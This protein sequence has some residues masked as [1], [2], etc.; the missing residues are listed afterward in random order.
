MKH[1]L[2]FILLTSFTYGYVGK[3]SS[4]KGEVTLTRDS[5][6]LTATTGLELHKKDTITTGADGKAQMIFQDETIVSIG[7]NSIFSIEEYLYDTQSSSETSVLFQVS[8]GVF[9]AI[10]GKIGKLNPKKFKLKTKTATIGIRGTV[11]FGDV[12]PNER[13]IIIC[14]QGSIVIE[15]PFGTVIVLEGEF[16]I[17]EQGKAPIPPAPLTPEQWEK[18]EKDATLGKRKVIEE[19]FKELAPKEP[20]EKKQEEL[21]GEA[22]NI[23]ILDD[24]QYLF[25]PPTTAATLFNV[26]TGFSFPLG[27]DYISFSNSEISSALGSGWIKKIDDNDAD[28]DWGYWGTGNFDDIYP[29]SNYVEAVWL[30]ATQ[31]VTD[32]TTLSGTSRYTGT[33]IGYTNES[34]GT[35]IDPADSSIALTFDFGANTASVAMKVNGST[36]YNIPTAQFTTSGNSYSLS[37]GTNS[38]S[39]EF[40]NDG[41]KTAGSFSIKKPVANITAK[42]VFK[43]TKQ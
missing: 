28:F 25:D 12:K 23:I 21:L 6:P 5:K 32:I 9:K 41:A 15:T 31:G 30:K 2:L 36:G 40:Y 34:G 19:L 7:Y 16:T 18:L 42:G 38:V 4:H 20:E 39:G 17:I 27:I 3:I 43:A 37:N 13:E 11:F 26:A 22:D 8:Q 14:T 33:I 10:T 24:T 35:A 29:Q 1:L